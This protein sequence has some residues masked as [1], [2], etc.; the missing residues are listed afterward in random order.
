MGVG[1]G[2]WLGCDHVEEKEGH[3]PG[4]GAQREQGNQVRERDDVWALS[5]FK[6][7]QNILNSFKLDSIQTGLSQTQK[8]EIKY[9]CEGFDVRNI[10]P[11]WNFSIFEMGF[12]IKNQGS[13]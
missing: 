3:W 12:W 11:Y 8:I 4:G 1:G 5:G 9:G 7:F 2:R 10:F 13:F 6:L